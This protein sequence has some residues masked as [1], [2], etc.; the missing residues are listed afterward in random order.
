MRAIFKLIGFLSAASAGFG[1]AEAGW[2]ET[3]WGMSPDIVQQ[4]LG[5]AARLDRGSEGDSLGPSLTVGNKGEYSAGELTFDTVFY[6]DR[7][8][9]ALV[10]LNLKQGQCGRVRESLNARYG[11]P[12]DEE[13]SS[14]T[15]RDVAANNKIFIKV[16]ST[17]RCFISYSPLKPLRTTE[18]DAL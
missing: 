8:G 1:V 7:G 13:P 14:T 16:W 9:L 2:Q 5:A 15:W 11:D 18:S 6:Y 17:D 12:A 4:K 3:Q 10:R